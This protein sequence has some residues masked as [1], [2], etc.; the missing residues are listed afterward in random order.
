MKK[1]LILII[2]CIVIAGSPC[3]LS[4]QISHLRKLKTIIPKPPKLSRGIS[5]AP[6]RRYLPYKMYTQKMLDESLKTAVE[7]GN[8]PEIRRLIEAGADQKH[9]Q[10]RL[11]FKL[12]MAIEN[13]IS[14]AI[15]LVEAGVN[16]IGNIHIAVMKKNIGLLQAI[17]ASNEI[18]NIGHPSSPTFPDL[19]HTAAIVAKNVNMIDFLISQG[20]NPSQASFYGKT[21][22][23]H[24]VSFDKL[25]NAEALLKAG[26][27]IDKKDNRGNPAYGGV[28]SVPML[29]L[30]MRWGE[31]LIDPNVLLQ[32]SPKVY[33]RYKRKLRNERAG[34]TIIEYSQTLSKD[35]I[36]N[37][38]TKTYDAKGYLL[39]ED[40]E[41]ITLEELF[42]QRDKDYQLVYG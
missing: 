24:A 34:K 33:E 25:K 41:T 15:K 37:K 4:A 11:N 39:K 1:Q 28:K 21:P 31:T 3:E 19:L 42:I 29:E 8:I 22:L 14:E 2:S 7:T 13:D 36:F 5:Y 26:A 20:I 32:N 40:T 10:K 38:T 30:L 16:P 9:V 12:M 6:L 23:H 18:K 35:P 27:Q 17:F